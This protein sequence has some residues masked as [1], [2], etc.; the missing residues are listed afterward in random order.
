MV[1]MC[2]EVGRVGRVV[3]SVSVSVSSSK[4]MSTSLDWG[5]GGAVADRLVAEDAV[6][7]GVQGWKDRVPEC[8]VCEEGVDR[9][10]R[11]EG[12]GY[13]GGGLELGLRSGS[14]L[15]LKLGFRVWFRSWGWHGEWQ[16]W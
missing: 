9:L 8:E 4:F 14:R 12:R 5:V 16:V 13:A 1:V 6:V 3:V 10:F 2:K 15:R 7:V 11:P